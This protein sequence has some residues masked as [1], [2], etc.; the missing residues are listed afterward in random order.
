VMERG[1]GP[2]YL[3]DGRM[4]RPVRICSRM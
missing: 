2:T 4:R 3:A 1:A